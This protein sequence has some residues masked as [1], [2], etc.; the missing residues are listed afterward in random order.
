MPVL[1]QPRRHRR[2]VTHSISV[3]RS[4]WSW[5]VQQCHGAAV[6]LCSQ[7]GC[8]LATGHGGESGRDREGQEVHPRAGVYTGRRDE[9]APPCSF[10]AR[11]VARRAAQKAFEGDQVTVTRDGGSWP[12]RRRRSHLN[13]RATGSKQELQDCQRRQVYT[14][15]FR[16]HTMRRRI[17]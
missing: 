1:S 4:A 12:T 13:S 5:S 16:A 7:S 8:A 15:S 2:V 9:G 11:N 10:H 6:N 14:P 17:Q 3:R